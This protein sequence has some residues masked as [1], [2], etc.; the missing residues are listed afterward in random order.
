MK[1]TIEY[2][3]IVR[4]INSITIDVKNEEEG[5]EVANKLY[6]KASRYDHPDCIFDDLRNMGIKVIETCEGAEDCEYEIQ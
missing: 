4:K 3:E 5:E 1:Y 6:N 2:E